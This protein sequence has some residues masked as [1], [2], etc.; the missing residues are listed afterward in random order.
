M[1]IAPQLIT[2]ESNI[3]DDLGLDSLDSVELIIALED[4]FHI[5]IESEDAEQLKTVGDVADLV[6]RLTA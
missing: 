2:P 1:D 6:D 5:N 4:E 3:T